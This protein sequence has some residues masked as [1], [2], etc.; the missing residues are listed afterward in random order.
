MPFADIFVQIA[1]NLV[2]YLALN[3]YSFAGGVIFEMRTPHTDLGGAAL[4]GTSIGRGD[5][6]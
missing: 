2:A 4:H 1:N 6:L 5:G 3:I